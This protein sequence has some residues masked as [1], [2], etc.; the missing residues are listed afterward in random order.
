ML[1]IGVCIY[2]QIVPL[3]IFASPLSGRSTSSASERLS[4]CAD[5]IPVT[6]GHEAARSHIWGSQ[7]VSILLIIGCWLGGKR[8]PP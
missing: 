2:L 4:R 8:T 5:V 3:F 7:M 1:E 6:D